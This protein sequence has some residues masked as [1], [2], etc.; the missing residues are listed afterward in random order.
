MMPIGERIRAARKA[1]G[2]TQADLGLR[3]GISYQSIGQWERGLRYPTLDS[4]RKLAE[5]LE[6]PVCALCCGGACAGDKEREE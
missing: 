6:M 2:M 5:A 3:L 4:L 1:K